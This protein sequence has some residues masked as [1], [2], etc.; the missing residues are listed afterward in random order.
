MVIMKIDNINVFF[1]WYDLWIGAYWS[2]KDN[3]LYI[4]PFFCIVVKLVFKPARK[5]Y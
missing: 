4:C 5:I 2:I 3:T 1:A